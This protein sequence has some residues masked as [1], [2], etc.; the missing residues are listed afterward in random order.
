M[1]SEAIIRK[2]IRRADH[3]VAGLRTVLRTVALGRIS[4]LIVSVGLV[5]QKEIEL[6]LRV[7]NRFV[8]DDFVKVIPLSHHLVVAGD[9]GKHFPIEERLEGLDYLFLTHFYFENI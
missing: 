9:K 5:G 1:F 3:L 4:A 2:V 6:Y 7:V 8:A